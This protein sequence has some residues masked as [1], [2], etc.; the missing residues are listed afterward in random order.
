M[1]HEPLNTAVRDGSVGEKTDREDLKRADL[2]DVGKKW[3]KA[4]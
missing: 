1:P 3:T 4:A 2:G